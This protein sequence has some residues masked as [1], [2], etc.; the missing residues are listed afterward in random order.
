MHEAP[1]GHDLAQKE[2]LPVTWLQARVAQ[3]L[4][5]ALRFGPRGSCEVRGEGARTGA[6]DRCLEEDGLVP[7]SGE[8][9]RQRERDRRTPHAALAGN[10]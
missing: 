3:V 5:H 6:P 8:G 7:A 1:D 10:E 4:V 9:A 2:L